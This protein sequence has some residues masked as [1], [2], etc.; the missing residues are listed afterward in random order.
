ML[1]R[2]K[3]KQWAK[4]DNLELFDEIFDV[5]Q[6]N[7]TNS[8]ADLKTAFEENNFFVRDSGRFVEIKLHL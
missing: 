1:L 2:M 5:K 6:F 8:Y 4:K 7:Y 3:I